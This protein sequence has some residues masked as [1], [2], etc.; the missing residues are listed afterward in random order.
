MRILDAAL[1][2]IN[3]RTGLIDL[4]KPMATHPVPPDTG[5]FYVFGSA[6]LVSFGIQM[7]T[8]V[9]LATMFV[10]SSSSAYQ[11]LDFITNSATLGSVI[12]GMHFWGASSMILFIGAHMIRVFLTGSFKFPREMNWVSGVVLLLLTVGM[13]FTGQLLRWD[14]NAV[15]SVIV[16]AEQAGRVPL[17]GHWLARLLLAGGTLSSVTLSRFFVL[18]VFVLPGLIF[19]T[20]GL[21]LYLVLRHG[22]SEPPVPGRRVAV[23]DYRSFYERLLERSGVPFWPSAAWR[24]ALFGLAVLLGVLFLAWWFGPPT[25]GRIPD[26]TIIQAQPRPDWYLLWYFAVLALLPHGAE[27]YMIVFGPPLAGL[28]LLLLPFLFP[29]GERS[30]RR[31]PWAVAAVLTIVLSVAV[32][33]RAGV[34]APW[35]PDFEAQPLSTEVIGA[36]SGPVFEG[37]A[38][39]AKRGC[40]YCHSISGDGGR[41]GPN[42]TTV[43]SRLTKR[44]MIIRILNGGYNMPGYSSILESGEL[45]ELVRFLQT[46]TSERSSEAN[47]SMHPLVAE[48]LIDAQHDSIGAE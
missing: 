3:D 11:S 15:W 32:L 27:N 41:R 35:S 33:W 36:S 48:R 45:E 9:V 34:E 25:L 40:V 31:R 16:G 18:H 42:L 26:P 43:G 37:A 12:R 6:I 46:R 1:D 21:H 2:W 10:P 13:G 7:V 29:T 19:V 14:Q 8:G 5:W 20:V 39:F 23:D 4:L 47:L 28:V 38:L 30:P 24:D 22:I 17:L 44:Q